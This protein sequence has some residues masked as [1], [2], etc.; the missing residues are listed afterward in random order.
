MQPPM[1]PQKRLRH[2]NHLHAHLRGGAE[3]EKDD[4]FMRTPTWFKVLFAIAGVIGVGFL[5][6]IVWAIVMLVSWVVSQ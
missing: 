5:A 1:D 4:D 2:Q 6:L 3:S